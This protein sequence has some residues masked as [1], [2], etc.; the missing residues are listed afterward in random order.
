MSKIERVQV[1]FYR[2]KTIDKFITEWSQKNSDQLLWH[3]NPKKSCS[4]SLIQ[5]I[6]IYH[7]RARI[8]IKKPYLTINLREKFGQKRK[9]SIKCLQILQES[10]WRE[11][12]L[13]EKLQQDNA[14]AHNLIL[15]K[16]WFSK[17]DKKFSKTGHRIHQTSILS[18]MFGVC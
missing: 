17:K 1:D 8:A 9:N 16:T 2:G 14:P 18:K 11:M 5:R 3:P 6:L 15:W 12:F 7:L 4:T 10:F 13:G